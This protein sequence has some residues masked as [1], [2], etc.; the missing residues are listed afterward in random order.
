MQVL[1]CGLK[2]FSTPSRR[3][4]RWTIRPNALLATHQPTNASS[5]ES[6]MDN[7][8]KCSME[9]SIAKELGSKMFLEAPSSSLGKPESLP[10]P[11]LDKEISLSRARKDVFFFQLNY[12]ESPGKATRLWGMWL[13][14][15]D[16]LCQHQSSSFVPWM[17]TTHRR[18]CVSYGQGNSNSF[19]LQLYYNIANS[20]GV[21]IL[22]NKMQIST[23]R[24]ER[25]SAPI[26][27]E[28]SACKRRNLQLSWRKDLE[29]SPSYAS[30]N[31]P[32]FCWQKQGSNDVTG[33]PAKLLTPSK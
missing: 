2:T 11:L 17:L 18:L 22:A 28:C 6:S 12:K 33:A 15:P 16:R 23:T 19:V 5:N 1:G 21:Q 3:A 27:G 13:H 14:A 25:V 8:E 20:L 4:D 10:P 29:P 30:A 26:V 32:Q 24:R 31:Q 7:R 9:K